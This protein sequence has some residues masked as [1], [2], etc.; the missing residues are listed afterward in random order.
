MY[1][2]RQQPTSK[3]VNNG[4]GLFGMIG[5]LFGGL[6][7]SQPSFNR[8]P[9]NSSMSNRNFKQSPDNDI[10]NIINN[11]HSKIS[12]HINDDNKI[13]TLSISDEEITSII[14]D[15]TDVNILKKAVRGKN[16]RTLN[17]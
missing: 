15:A 2:Q 11:V 17:I 3:P 8:S 16:K 1:N 10:N 4:G 6:N 12:T 7:N 13:E 5:N 9:A 14:E